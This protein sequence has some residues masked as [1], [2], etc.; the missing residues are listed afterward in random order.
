MATRLSIRPQGLLFGLG[1]LLASSFGTLWSNEAS[2]DEP[3]KVLKANQVTNE[4][5]NKAYQEEAAKKRLESIA[6]LKD[7]LSQNTATGDQ[8]AEM[9]LRLAD[10]YFQQ[11]RYLYLNEM[12]AFDVVYQ[13]CF[14]DPKCAP[15]L[16]KMKPDNT[17]SRDWQEKSI[18]LYEQILRSYPRYARADEATFYLGSALSD[19]GK[20]DEALD[21]FTNLVK[22]YPNSTWVPDAYVNIGE[23]WFEHNE[24]AKALL[25][26][27]KVNQKFKTSPMYGFATYKMAWCLYNVGEYGKAID[28]MK[29]VI[30]LSK[31]GENKSK[32]QLQDEA[33]KDLVRFFAD[34]DMLDEAYAYFTQQGKK[35]LITDML[36]RLGSTYFEQGKWDKAIET[37]RRLIAENP[38][39]PECPTYQGEIIKAYKKIGDKPTTLNEVDRLLKT[40]GKSSAWRKANASNADGVKAAENSI[41]LNLRQIAVDYH[42]AAKKLGTGEEAKQTYALAYRAYKTYLE[43]YESGEHA[44]EVRYAFGELLYKI[45]KYDEA[46]DQYMRVVKINPNGTHSKFCAESSI[47]AAEEMIKAEGGGNAIKSNSPD[48][49]ALKNPQPLTAWEQKLVDA[50]AQYAKLYKDDKVNKVIYKTGYLLYNKYRFGEAAEQ[51]NLVIQKEPGSKEAEAASHLMLDSFKITEDWENL[52]K[53]AK[54]YRDQ[55][56]LGGAEFKKEVGEIYMRSSFKVIEESFK[57]DSNKNTAADS[58]LAFYNEFPDSDVSAQALNNASVYYHD[59]NR[60][61]DSITVRKILIDDPKFGPKTKYYYDQISNLGFDYEAIADFA[62]A[63]AY[64]EKMFS[65]YPAEVEKVKKAIA[66]KKEGASQEKLDQ[67][68]ANAAAALYSAAVFRRA[69]GQWEQ[70]INDYKQFYTAFPT[71]SKNNDIKLTIGKIYEDQQKW[72][73]AA[74]VYQSFYTAKNAKESLPEFLYF[75]RLHHA[76]ALEKLG[77]R[78]KQIDIY[79]ESVN[80]YNKFIAAGGKPGTHTE[81]V[82]EMMYVLAAPKFDA[83]AALKIDAP[84]GGSRSAEDK[85]LQKSLK[86]KTESLVAIEKTYTEIIKTGA[87]EWGLASLVVLG[88]VYENMAD[89][90]KNSHVPSYLDADQRD[91]YRM[92]IEDRTYPQVE[93]AVAAYSAALSKS[94]EL[95]LYNDDTGFATRRLGELRPDDYPGLSERVLTPRYTSSSKKSYTFESEL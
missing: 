47:F 30:D 83:Y 63:A 76:K 71:D 7:L 77:Q 78:A 12:E 91:M 4:D 86:S 39:A 60:V 79:K 64:Y 13:K 33:Y 89:S 32:L 69:E 55:P 25:A 81:F 80:E 24:A 31:S 68:P 82:A 56:G 19:T 17:Q 92:A 46:Y 34:A 93:K 51:F 22:Q 44:Y 90:L 35:S 18:K 40:Y 6:F 15:N 41:E 27:Q 14:D 67:M 58:F 5:R 16:E 10:L 23:Y 75:A 9:M 53:N 3:R 1:F 20:K 2:A 36:K 26:Y 72:S 94:Y 74:N 43:E 49:T 21:Q 42:T 88:K 61:A 50:C 48:P 59:M 73:E 28:A 37:Y 54:I 85:A 8:K 87:G 38:N 57:K 52:K 45:K 84:K 70:A 66:E 29:S 95:T 65:L 11:G 62:K